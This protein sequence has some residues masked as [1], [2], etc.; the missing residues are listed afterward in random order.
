MPPRSTS[1]SRTPDHALATLLDELRA[2]H[3]ALQ[4]ASADPRLDRQALNPAYRASAQN[5]LA[6]LALRDGDLHSLQ[7]QLS[8][9]GL[10]SLGRSEAAV[11]P[12]VTT[13]INT[14]ERLLGGNPA[15]RP[16]TK[17]ANPLADH[18]RTLFGT[19]SSARAVRIMVTLPREA[20]DNYS[21]VR[22]LLAAHM[23]CARIN[24]AHD[25]PVSW[26]RMIEHVRR[27]SAELDR[28]CRVFMDL[29]GPKLRTGPI[30]T[31]AAVQKVKP[32]RDAQGRVRHPARIWLTGRRRSRPAPSPAAASI[33]VGERWLSGLQPGDRIQLTDT[34]RAQ[35]RWT[36]VEVTDRGCW[37]EAAKTT[38]LAP[39]L[40]LSVERDGRKRH[41]RIGDFA[42]QPGALR[43]AEDDLLILTADQ[44]PGQPAS[45]DSG[46]RLLTPATL[47]CTLP[48]V[49][50]DVRGGE[51]VWFDDGK[52]G[53]VIERADQDALH[54]RITHAPGGAKLKGDKGINF[55][56]ST[57]RLAALGDQDL[58]ALAFAAEHADGIEMSFVNSAEDVRALLV[59]LERLQADQ[60]AVVLKI[61]T[62]RGFDN[63][64]ALLLAGMQRGGFGV[65]IARGDLAVEGGFERLAALQEDILCLCEA[66]HVPVIWAT[67]VLENLAKKGSPS[68]A[69]I[70][71]AA[72]GVRAECV[73]LNKGPHI[74]KA[75][76]TLDELLVRMQGYNSK[77][78]QMLRKL[79]LASPWAD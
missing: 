47:G 64:P 67:Q 79:E 16:T 72:T 38:Y 40:R 73:M 26:R 34:R 62:R 2:L 11:L 1:R 65:M 43:L 30:A 35:R 19:P 25:E 55:P 20:A 76:A 49:F 29:P 50:A 52:I 61:E 31:G 57:L 56:Q 39:G 28:P 45:H 27:A 51:P 13:L 32:E 44:T 24:C 77:K 9:L 15:A 68:R 70:T 8:A 22:D 46:G 54:V 17:T 71:D 10:S 66:A 23:D 18:A 41:S 58:A 69:E 14:L 7:L 4:Q 21:L 36:I 5:L 48:Q 37:A 60:L 3:G 78:R 74:L 75:V 59:E 42:P 53:G 6:Y 12:A 33:Q 63:L